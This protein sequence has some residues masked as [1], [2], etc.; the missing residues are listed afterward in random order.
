MEAPA[1]AGAFLLLTAYSTVVPANAGMTAGV[2][3]RPRLRRALFSSN[4]AAIDVSRQ[5]GGHVV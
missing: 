1:R 3:Q 4:C 2:W 5:A